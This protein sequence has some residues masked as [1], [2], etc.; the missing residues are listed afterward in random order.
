MA[1]LT[2]ISPTLRELVTPTVDVYAA[3]VGFTAG[4]STYIDLTADPGSENNVHITFDGVTQHHDTY[5]I[6]GVRVT[7]DAAIPTGVAK[8]EARY[9]QE[10]PNYTVVADG[11]ITASKLATPSRSD[12]NV[13]NVGLAAAVASSALTISLKGWDG[14]DPSASNVVIIPFRSSTASI[15][16]VTDR[17]VTSATSV[18][19]PSTAT[20]G[21][22]NDIPFR[23]WVVALDNAGTVGLGA[24]V[25]TIGTSIYGLRDNVL[26]DAVA[27]GTGADSAQ[28]IYATSTHTDDAIRVLGYM[29]WTSGLAAVGTWDAVPNIIQLYHHGINLPGTVV[30][31]IDG[32]VSVWVEGDNA[33]IPLDDTIPQSSE[34]VEVGTTTVSNPGAVVNIGKFDC[35]LMAYS[36]SGGTWSAAIFQDS[37]SDAFACIYASQ[38]NRAC[39]NFVALRQIGTTASTVYKLRSGEITGHVNNAYGGSHA[40][41]EFGGVMKY[42]IVFTEYMA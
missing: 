5:S 14:S 16:T 30:Q 37:E 20:M 10:H 3:G 39:L 1:Y 4:S 36:A 23:I 27:V 12:N 24:I 41:R 40:A 26:A 2:G 42:G 31:M 29:D 35:Q 7:F 17:Q 8:I 6:S 21:Q 11:S 18:V 34:G 15:G 9:A 13:S 38:P 22:T 28:V 25:T 32:M 33:R 19:I